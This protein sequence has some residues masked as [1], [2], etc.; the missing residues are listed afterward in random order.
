ML[1]TDDDILYAESLLLKEGESFNDERRN[2]IKNLDNVDILASPGSGKT[3]ALLAKLAILSTK[4]SFENNKGICILT[5]TNTAIDEVK[6][7]LGVSGNNL[8]RYPNNCSTIQSFVNQF[9]AIPAYV[10]FY[11]KRPLRID[12]EIYNEVISK[13]FYNH[14][15]WN[16]QYGIQKMNINVTKIRFNLNDATLVNGLYGNPIYKNRESASYIA[17]KKLKENIM[18][19]GI[20]CYDDAY[21]LAFKYLRANPDL[22]E[23]FSKRFRHLFI[24]EMQDTMEHQIAILGLI[25]DETVIIQRIG[26]PNQAIYDGSNATG[27]WDINKESILQISDSKRFSRKIASVVQNICITPQELVGNLMIEEIAPRILVFN[28]DNQENVF[29]HFSRLIIKNNLHTHDESIF[30]AV[31]WV[32]EHENESGIT[33]YRNSYKKELKKKQDFNHLKSYLLKGNNDE[34]INNGSNYYRSRI[35][36][37]LLKAL[38]IMNEKNNNKYFTGR[39]FLI[40]LQENNEDVFNQLLLNLSIWCLKIQNDEEILDEVISFITCEIKE[41]FNW[42]DIYRLDV[43]LQA[44]LEDVTVEHQIPT[45]VFTFSED[46]IEVNIAISSIHGV[47]GETHTA[48]LYLETFYY[49][50]DIKRII[51]YLKGQHIKTTAKRKLQNLKMAYVGMTRPSHLLCV[52]VSEET[53]SGH[54]EELKI[55]GWEIEYLDKVTIA[56]P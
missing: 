56:Q 1:L 34:I 24:D 35:L 13:E 51:E 3:T 36:R 44:N 45:N 52:A 11:G 8:F 39:S 23:L 48:T 19:E 20:L 46:D 6:S 26:D 16:L 43:F 32:A 53:I 2:I 28:E 14:L 29:S 18:E 55:A 47:K 40:Y 41:I 21:Y 5:H 10:H 25:F 31:G 4:L 49:D 30:K 15:P 54:E 7:R 33:N 38:R 9:L 27:S 17:L 42:S 12:N 37:G 50:Y 22:K